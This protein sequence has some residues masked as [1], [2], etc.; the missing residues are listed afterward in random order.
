MKKFITVKDVQDVH[1]LVDVAAQM[2]ANPFGFKEVG[3]NKTLGI[4]FFNPSLRT[5]LSTQRAATNLGMNVM[6]MNFDNE[7]WKLETEE[8]AIMNGY[9]QEHI[10]D[11]ALVM[12]QYCDVLGIRTFAGLKNR[13]ED[14]AE[15]FLTKFLQYVTVPVVSLESATAHPL[16][17][18]ADMLTIR[19]Q[20]TTKKPKV[21]LSWAPHPRALPQA[22]ANSFAEWTL[23][24]GY[25]LTI[26]HPEGYELSE[27][28]TAGATITHHQEEALKDADFVYVK[29]WS[30]Y[31]NYGS[32][33]QEYGDWTVDAE[34]M[35]LT[36]N[37][38]FMHCLP[39][40]RNVIATDEVVDSPNSLIIEQA[41]NRTFAAQAVLYK[42]LSE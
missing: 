32:A 27:E 28:F 33:S 18:L 7:G 6:V 37:G 20:T 1:A 12:S 36:N 15:S 8:G 10:S 31:R 25:D 4:I 19:E 39:L 5:R 22:V 34:K 9:K 41:N 42:M 2:K 3:T 21:V 16:Q 14:Y 24:S 11:A 38:H 23:A 17:S 13:E 29:N 40:R 35:K 26:T 30:S